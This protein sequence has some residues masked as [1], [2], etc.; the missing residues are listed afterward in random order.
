MFHVLDRLKKRTNVKASNILLFQS[1]YEGYCKELCNLEDLNI[2][3]HNPNSWGIPVE[4]CPSNLLFIQQTANPMVGNFDK[5][6]CIGA[7]EEMKMAKQLNDRFGIDLIC[8]HNSSEENYCP[9][10]F[11]FNVREKVEYSSQLEVS[12][13]PFF[14]R[15]NSIIIPPV[16]KDTPSENKKKSV[17][18][19]QHVPNDIMRAFHSASKVENLLEFN[20]DNL[21]SAKVFLDT[22]VGLTPHLIKALS[23][24][25]IPVLPY[26]VEAERLLGDKGY[27]YNGYEEL[28]GLVQEAISSSISQ[29]EIRDLASKC[30]TSKEDFINKWEYVLGRSS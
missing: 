22:I 11:S 3:V 1:G 29:Y 2:Y 12:M 8:V 20:S 9:R 15:Q 10:P 21:L 26:S 14:E 4:S 16:Y 19:F 25:C 28:S 18:I 24:G 6:L 7:A 17:C 23:F 5:I 27:F 30:F 13:L